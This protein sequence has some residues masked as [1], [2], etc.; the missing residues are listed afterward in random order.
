MEQG[1]NCTLSFVCF[2]PETSKLILDRID[3]V[4]VPQAAEKGAEAALCAIR[5]TASACSSVHFTR[6]QSDIFN[7]SKISAGLIS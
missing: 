7:F 1:D 5:L 6:A 2:N 4:T 3:D